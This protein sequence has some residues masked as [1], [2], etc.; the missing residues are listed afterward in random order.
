MGT[1]SN[2]GVLDKEGYCHIVYCHWDGY[3]SHTGKLLVKHY[4]T[5]EKVLDLIS[6]GD[7][8]SL[9]ELV[10]PPD[11]VVHDFIHPADGVCVFYHRDRG[12]PLSK[13]KIHSAESGWIKDGYHYLFK[14]GRW[15]VRHAQG[16][17][18]WYELNFEEETDNGI[19]K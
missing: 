14:T 9:G 16:D 19:S 10:R 15:Y 3:P 7:M 12:E 1:R 6:H 13:L 18:N 11:G 4:D 2:I 5:D 8:D 17:G